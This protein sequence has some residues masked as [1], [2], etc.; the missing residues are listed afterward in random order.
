MDR[1]QGSRIRV[2]W[3][4]TDQWPL[5]SDLWPLVSDPWLL[6]PDHDPWAVTPIQYSLTPNPWPVATDPCSITLWSR[7][8][9]KAQGSVLKGQ[10]SW[11]RGQGS[12]IRGHTSEVKGHGSSVTVYLIK[13]LRRLSAI[14][15]YVHFLKTWENRVHSL[16]PLNKFDK[17]IWIKYLHCKSCK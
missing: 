8:M 16:Q 1:G 14:V 2:Q 7:V 5:T 12:V 3:P 6:T 11:I 10:R 9:C 15:F 17:P 13:R 4:L